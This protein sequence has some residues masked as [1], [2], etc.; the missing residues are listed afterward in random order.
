MSVTFL[1]VYSL[2]N[3]S[4]SGTKS[5]R[6]V[7]AK[8]QARFPPLSVSSTTYVPSREGKVRAPFPNSG[9]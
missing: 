1:F 9:W 6:L 7:L 2:S 5:K 8:N 4:K 3:Y